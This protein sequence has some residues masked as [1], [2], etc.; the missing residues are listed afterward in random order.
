[1]HRRVGYDEKNVM[2]LASPL[3]VKVLEGFYLLLRVDFR[4]GLSFFM[5]N[6]ICYLHAV[7]DALRSVLRALGG[8][9]VSAITIHANGGDMG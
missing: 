2:H 4:L 1:M 6:M 7:I 3:A 9:S 5:A 8:M